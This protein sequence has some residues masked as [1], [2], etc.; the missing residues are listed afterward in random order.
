[1]ICFD[2]LIVALPEATP[3]RFGYV[4]LHPH[5]LSLWLRSAAKLAPRRATNQYKKNNR[6]K[7]LN[8]LLIFLYKSIFFD[9]LLVVLI[10]LNM[11]KFNPQTNIV[12]KFKN[13]DAQAGDLFM[14]Y[15]ITN[16]YKGAI[17]FLAYLKGQSE[18]DNNGMEQ[19][20]EKDER[21]NREFLLDKYLEQYMNNVKKYYQSN[22]KNNTNRD[23]NDSDL[24]KEVEKFDKKRLNNI[25][26]NYID[27]FNGKLNKT[28]QGG[29][30]A[31]MT[32]TEYECAMNILADFNGMLTE[33]K[34][35]QNIYKNNS[36]IGIR[37]N[38]IQEAKKFNALTEI[39]KISKLKNSIKPEKVDLKQSIMPGQ[40]INLDLN[41]QINKPKNE[42]K[43]NN[44]IKNS[45]NINNI[46][47]SIDDEED[48]KE[49]PKDNI[50][51]NLNIEKETAKFK[52]IDAKKKKTNKIRESQIF[53]NNIRINNNS[54]SKPQNKTM[55]IGSKSKRDEKFNP[56]TTIKRNKPNLDLNKVQVNQS[57]MLPKTNEI[58]DKKEDKKETKTDVKISK[59]N[60]ND[61]KNQ[62]NN[63]K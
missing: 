61:K 53:D 37:Q 13:N 26:D 27:L 21:F 31:K 60:V 11:E 44:E 63:K 43:N 24:N 49:E 2:L 23:Y 18:V 38:L 42:I 54:I 45:I 6:N 33:A 20:K 58:E 48:K 35:E 59:E 57:M 47:Y 8:F 46:N 39:K 34:K 3:S 16:D 55:I 10:V 50:N 30:V 56:Q 12:K 1:M 25:I 51:E 40:R 19:L 5:S 15:E 62:I 32:L 52:K 17:E 14:N 36:S 9:K 22:Y 4:S 41:T 28:K 29:T 7:N